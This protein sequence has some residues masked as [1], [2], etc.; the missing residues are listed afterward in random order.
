MW[1]ILIILILYFL[2]SSYFTRRFQNTEEDMK[3]T[4]PNPELYSTAY[5]LGVEYLK[6]IKGGSP[7]QMVMFDIDDTLLYVNQNGTLSPIKSIIKLLKYSQKN[8]FK[9]FI[10]TARD[11]RYIEETK[12]DLATNGITY[13]YLYLRVS[14]QDDYSTFKSDIKKKY[15]EHYGLQ[16]VFSIGDNDIDVNGGYSGYCIKLPNKTDPRLF[17]INMYGQLENVVP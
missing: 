16:T 3:T 9:V 17:H 8:G 12:K 6:I 13:D 5:D 7:N 10:L 4:I 14:P 15:Y 11:S 2:Y 1:I